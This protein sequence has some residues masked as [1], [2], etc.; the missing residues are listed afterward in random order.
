MALY[1]LQDANISAQIKR[2]IGVAPG[3]YELRCAD[4]HTSDRFI[5]IG[6]LLET[7]AQGILYIGSS[8]ASVGNRV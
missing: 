3:C 8:G 6:R 5:R 4:I 2:D 7:D 1:S